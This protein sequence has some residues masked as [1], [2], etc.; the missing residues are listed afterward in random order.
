MGLVGLFVDPNEA[1]G[2][3]KDAARLITGMFIKL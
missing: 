2:Y 1:F 3:S